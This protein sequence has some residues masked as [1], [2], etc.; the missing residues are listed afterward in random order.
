MRREHAYMLKINVD[1]K[2][3]GIS[4]NPEREELK[5]NEPHPWA[6]KVRRKRR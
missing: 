6:G 2:K 3:L 1:L 4:L 5:A